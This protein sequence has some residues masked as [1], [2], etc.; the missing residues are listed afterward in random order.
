M[1]LACLLRISASS[2][3]WWFASSSSASLQKCFSVASASPNPSLPSGAILRAVV[4]FRLSLFNVQ[5]QHDLPVRVL[6]DLE[7][8]NILESLLFIGGNLSSICWR[9]W[10]YRMGSTRGRTCGSKFRIIRLSFPIIL[11]PWIPHVSSPFPFSSRPSPSLFEISVNASIS[12]IIITFLLWLISVITKP[13]RLLS[14]FRPWH[15]IHPSLTRL[16]GTNVG[17]IPASA[18]LLHWLLELCIT[19]TMTK[20]SRLLHS[21]LAWLRSVER[22]RFSDNPR[23]W[24]F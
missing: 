6:F 1:I 3:S 4:L 17:W 18:S 12:L 9:R 11:Y 23:L 15:A 24:S 20:R 5:Y 21:C 8:A 19:M 2:V 14:F 7:T 13:C 16:I 10:R 22:R